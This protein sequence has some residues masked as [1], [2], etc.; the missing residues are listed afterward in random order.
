[1]KET[2]LTSYCLELIELVNLRHSV[3][4]ANDVKIQRGY[5]LLN[6]L[7]EH[8]FGYAQVPITRHKEEIS[9]FNVFSWVPAANKTKETIAFAAHFDVVNSK[10]DNVNDNTASVAN[11]LSL[12]KVLANEAPPVN[13]LFFFTDLE[14]SGGIGASLTNDY[15]KALKNKYD[16]NLAGIV[17][18]EL[19]AYGKAVWVEK[20]KANKYQYLASILKE[21]IDSYK[22]QKQK[23]VTV[24]LTECPFSDADVFSTKYPSICIGTIPVS[25]AM[26][27]GKKVERE[28]WTGNKKN[29]KKST[30]KT[31]YKPS[32]WDICHSAKDSL[33][34]A[35]HADMYDFV[36]I[37]KEIV[38]SM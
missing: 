27:V 7:K 3:N 24:V 14:E 34:T 15:I 20:S 2:Q 29:R 18:L 30:Y 6:W 12:M 25:E 5:Y 26:Q 36:E 4:T 21:G 37:L 17:N 38:F 35:K 8:G 13:V 28:Y 23:H 10:S 9:D 19:T 11:L 22:E 31:T 32:T 16:F 1:M 33:D